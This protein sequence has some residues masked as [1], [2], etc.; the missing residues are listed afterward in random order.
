MIVEE[1]VYVLTKQQVIEDLKQHKHKVQ[2]TNCKH[3]HDYAKRKLVG[4]GV[5]WSIVCPKCDHAGY[6]ILE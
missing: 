6:M 5:N 2:C 3:T 1:H 4:K